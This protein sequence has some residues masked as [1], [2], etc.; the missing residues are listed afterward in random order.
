MQNRIE[1]DGELL[2]RFG[3]LI[4][5]IYWCFLATRNKS[6]QL[7]LQGNKHVVEQQPRT[8][9]KVTLNMDRDINYRKPYLFENYGKEIAPCIMRLLFSRPSYNSCSRILKDRRKKKKS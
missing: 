8:N 7:S 5:H 9:G 6:C 1:G 3:I 2:Y 4:P